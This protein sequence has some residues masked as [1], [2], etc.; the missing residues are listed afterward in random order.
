MGAVKKPPMQLVVNEFSGDAIKSDPQET[1][2]LL[3]VTPA[4]VGAC[5]PFA[6]SEQ[7]VVASNLTSLPTGV[8]PR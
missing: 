1:T 5:V 2:V 3:P 6:L 7:R 8:T 4:P